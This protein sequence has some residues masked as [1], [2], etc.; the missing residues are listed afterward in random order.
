MD[1]KLVADIENDLLI[2]Y[3]NAVEI[4]HQHKILSS[5]EVEMLRVK[6]NQLMVHFLSKKQALNDNYQACIDEI[7]NTISIIHGCLNVFK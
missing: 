5:K 7:D 4:Q 3:G 6:T 2:I 1:K